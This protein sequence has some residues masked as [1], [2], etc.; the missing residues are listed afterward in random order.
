[1][2]RHQEPVH[3]RPR[4]LD[5]QPDGPVLTF[6]ERARTL[7][8]LGRVGTLATIS[9]RHDRW[10]FGSIMP[11]GLDERGH[12]AFLISTMAMHTQNLLSDH[13]ASLLVAEAEA[14][15]DP[16][17]AG[18]VTLMGK[19]ARIPDSAVEAARADYLTRHPNASYWVDFKDFAFFR[20]KVVDVYFVG[21][22]G[23]MGWVSAEEYALAKP[24]PLAESARGII[25]HMNADHVDAMLLLSRRIGH[26]EGQDARM[27]AVDRFGF[28][29]R[30]TTADG[31]K[32]LRI[33]FDREAH[34]AETARR[35]LVEM[36]HKARSAEQES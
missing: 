3:A 33:P 28:H 32:G 24:D 19:A 9:R 2:T 18:R 16:L 27:T 25:D 1:M 23:V 20:M 8:H 6:A 22:F 21:G 4:R 31:M 26:T 30:V 5:P 17:G 10:P 14:V 12:P 11:F 13:R 29:M 36:V 7:V 34:S 35:V 15:S